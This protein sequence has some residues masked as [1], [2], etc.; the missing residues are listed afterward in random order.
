MTKEPFRR[1][2]SERDNKEEIVR[3]RGDEGR[4]GKRSERGV[5]E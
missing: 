3:E 1:R 4:E 5:T 2:R